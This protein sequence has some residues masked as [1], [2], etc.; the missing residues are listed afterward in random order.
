MCGVLS[1]VIVSVSQYFSTE[2]DFDFDRSGGSG[3]SDSVLLLLS[4]FLLLLFLLLLLRTVGSSSKLSTL[5]AFLPESHPSV[6]ASL[7]PIWVGFCLAGLSKM[8]STLLQRV[9]FFGG[10]GGLLKYDI[11]LVGGS[12]VLRCRGAAVTLPPP[13]PPRC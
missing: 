7:D 6:S 8:R 3:G 9:S 10:N 2:G 1:T 11:F 4:L 12:E 13:P 5:L